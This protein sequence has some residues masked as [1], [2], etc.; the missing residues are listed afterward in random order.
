MARILGDN[1]NNVLL[2]D[3]DKKAIDEIGMKDKC[4]IC[5]K[6]FDNEKD[7]ISLNYTKEEKENI[8]TELLS[9][10]E[11][12]KQIINKNRNNN[13]TQAVISRKRGREKTGKDDI[14]SSPIIKRPKK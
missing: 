2:Y 13:N 14:T 10:K 8:K 7:L 11:R 5:G 6:D 4:L 3:K 12:K 1:G 9:L